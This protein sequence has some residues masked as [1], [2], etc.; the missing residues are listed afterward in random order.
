MKSLRGVVTVLLVS[1]RH[2]RE[3]L[4]HKQTDLPLQGSKVRKGL[5]C[6]IIPEFTCIKLFIFIVEHCKLRQQNMAIFSCTSILWQGFV[7]CDPAGIMRRV[8]HDWRGQNNEA[9]WT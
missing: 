4:D 7:I 9:N 1:N 2:A 6:K 3:K 5:F 8:G